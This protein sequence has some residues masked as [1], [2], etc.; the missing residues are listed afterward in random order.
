[1]IGTAK[2]TKKLALIF[3]TKRNPTDGETNLVHD[4]KD[5]RKIKRQKIQRF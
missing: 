1:M 5:S 2:I 4:W 3:L